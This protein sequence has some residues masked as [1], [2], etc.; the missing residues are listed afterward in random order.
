MPSDEEVVRR[1]ILDARLRTV[2]Y[3]LWTGDGTGHGWTDAMA[4]LGAPTYLRVS[5]GALL[6]GLP[7][8]PGVRGLILDGDGGHELAAVLREQRRRKLEIVVDCAGPA[9]AAAPV[10]A[11][12]DIVRLQPS[13]GTV[14]RLPAVVPADARLLAGGVQSYDA[15]GR[16]RDAGYDLFQGRFFQ[17]TPA[18][19]AAA[20]L[21][22]AEIP[23]G[24]V[25]ALAELQA[26]GG[27]LDVLE[28]IIRNDV[29]LSYR[30]LRFVNSAAIGLP[31]TVG[32]VRQAIVLLG[33][34]QVRQ[35][36]TSLVLAGIEGRPDALLSSALIR[37]RTCE[38]L[39]APYG[40]QDADRAFTAGL[41][42]L[43]G[44]ILGTDPADAI[45]TLPLDAEV[46]AAILEHDGVF[47]RTL[48]K[49]IAYEHG[50]FDD[51]VLSGHA[52]TAVGLVYL[53]ALQWADAML[54]SGSRPAGSG[55]AAA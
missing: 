28:R 52:R 50:A 36:A 34:R 41:F 17:S 20:S 48:R 42:S 19:Q 37:A 3:E 4:A 21:G 47:G 49:V 11:V 18:G 15:F 7:V 35:W 26:G 32:S 29:G 46:R 30:L 43:L 8:P 33:V 25:G 16:L 39:F 5:P 23:A 14:P 54:D 53:D 31:R 9:S 12:A 44:A 38:Q 45:A 22:T 40:P 6:D 24:T 51:P 13:G 1:P 55:T 2:A 27:D 10:L